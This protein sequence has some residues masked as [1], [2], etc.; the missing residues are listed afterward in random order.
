MP[1]LD[2]SL[3]DPNSFFKGAANANQMAV[4]MAR[5]KAGKLLAAG[6]KKGAVD[7]LNQVGDMRGAQDLQV[8]LDESDD[9]LMKMNT[10]QRQRSTQLIVDAAHVLNTVRHKEGDAAILPAFEQ[11]VPMFKQNGASDQELDQYRQQLGGPNA[12]R[13]LESI[14]RFA[15]GHMKTYVTKPGDTVRAEDGSVVGTN[16]DRPRTVVGPAG[17]QV[18]EVPGAETP[19]VDADLA[20]GDED[21]DDE[22]PPVELLRPGHTS[23]FGNGQAWT[24]GPDNKP[25]RV[26]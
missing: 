10:L 24:I 12:G 7:T 25:Q 18:M 3:L 9:R 6:D 11:M 1:Q 4:Q 19:Q 20:G 13:F 15:L 16:P 23:T 14:H 8:R 22:T 21:G 2:W 5:Q 26:K 17:S